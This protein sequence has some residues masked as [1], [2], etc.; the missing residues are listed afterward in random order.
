MNYIGNYVSTT[1]VVHAVTQ[2]RLTMGTSM[3]GAHNILNVLDILTS[4][5]SIEVTCK[6]CIQSLQSADLL[7]PVQG[8]TSEELSPNN[9]VGIGKTAFVEYADGKIEKTVVGDALNEILITNAEDK[10]VGYISK[11]SRVIIVD[12]FREF[13]PIIKVTTLLKQIN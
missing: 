12:E 2:H 8:V 5:K 7:S 3:C 6:G 11:I 9:L 4:G 1:E 10:D 13:K